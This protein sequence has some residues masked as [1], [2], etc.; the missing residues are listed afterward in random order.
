MYTKVCDPS[1]IV[2]LFAL[3]ALRVRQPGASELGP[4]GS[5]YT[6]LHNGRRHFLRHFLPLRSAGDDSSQRLLRGR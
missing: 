3:T 1:S 2:R 5:W 4:G 6:G